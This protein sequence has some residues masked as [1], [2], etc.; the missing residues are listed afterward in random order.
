MP[1][2]R[3]GFLLRFVWLLP[4]LGNS[5]EGCLTM[6]APV[7]V[8]HIP[9]AST[10][11]PAAARSAIALSDKELQRE[12]L[13]MTDHFTDELF[14]VSENLAKAVKFPVSRLVVDPERFVNDRDEPM[15]EKGMG[16]IYTLTSSR[17]K[18]RKA[19]SMQEREE[20]LSMYYFPHHLRLAK[21]VDAVLAMHDRCLIV[22]AHSFPSRPLPHE[23]DQHPDRC[24]ICVGTDPFHTP[25]WL[26]DFTVH[27][28]RNRNYRVEVNRPFGGSLVPEKHYRRDNRVLSIMIEVNRALYMDEVSGERLAAFD[29]VAANLQQVLLTLIAAMSS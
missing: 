14:R 11:V 26:A 4:P 22:D 8:I 27:E 28:F 23:A 21:E 5:E 20:L 6:N 10:V 9:H 1:L 25:Q 17:Q 2:H 16:A 7:S 15:A 24:D 18:L 12:L 29:A 13:T 3:E 19:P